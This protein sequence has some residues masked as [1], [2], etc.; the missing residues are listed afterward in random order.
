MRSVIFFFFSMLLAFSAKSQQLPQ[1][2]QWF[3][4]QLAINPAHSGIKS[5]VEVKTQIRTQWLGLEGAPNS[6]NF[7]FSIPLYAKRKSFLSARHGLGARFERDQIGAFTGNRFNLSYAAHLNF[8]QDNRLSVGIGA[9]IQQWAYNKDKAT[10]VVADP[11]LA[12]SNT[13]IAPDANLGF[14]WNG[15]NYYFGLAIQELTR[16]SWQRISNDSRFKFHYSLSAGYRWLVKE[17]ITILP[18][19]IVRIPPKSKISADLNVI[20]DFNNQFGIGVGYRNTDAVMFF[21]NV[22]IKEQ[23]A[24]GYSFDYVLSSLGRNEFFT[25]E[26]SLTFSGCKALKVTKTG[27]PMF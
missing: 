25:H 18:S 23:F 5:C 4:N 13:M 26:I 3:W 12:Q 17:G 14:W 8:T 10:T 1:Y 2:S 27:C 7:T 19:A 16:S 22:K 15:K 6:G 9:G 24:I 21:M 20:V 11:L